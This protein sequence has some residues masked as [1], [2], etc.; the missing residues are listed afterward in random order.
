MR[1]FKLPLLCLSLLQALKCV[2]KK[3]I[4]VE[5]VEVSRG[6][7]V[8]WCAFWPGPVWARTRV[9]VCLFQSGFGVFGLR[10]HQIIM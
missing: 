4:K 5:G 10:Q 1:L 8:V 3:D 6:L 9:V 7:D 2:C